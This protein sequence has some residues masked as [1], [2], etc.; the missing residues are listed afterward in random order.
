[1][2]VDEPKELDELTTSDLEDILKW[3]EEELHIKTTNKV[4]NK[5]LYEIARDICKN[6][7]KP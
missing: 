6:W 3:L 7:E 1:M 5:P 2:G 4:Q